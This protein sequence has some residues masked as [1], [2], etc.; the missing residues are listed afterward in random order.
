MKHVFAVALIASCHV[1]ALPT[2]DADTGTISGNVRYTGE[3]P[4]VKKILTTDGATILH[5]DLVVDAKTKGLCFVLATLDATAQ[6]KLKKAKPVLVDQ[7]DMVF[8]P[9]VVAVRASGPLR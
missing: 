4:P 7:R 8:L 9:R 3:L 2:G 5:H 6:P 1:Y